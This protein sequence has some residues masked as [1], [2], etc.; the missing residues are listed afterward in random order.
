MGK[1]GLVKVTQSLDRTNFG[2]KID[3]VVH[4]A[5]SL[6]VIFEVSIFWHPA[7]PCQLASPHFPGSRLDPPGVE[8]RPET[9]FDALSKQQCKR[10][11]RCGLITL[12]TSPVPEVSS[13]SCSRGLQGAAGGFLR[14]LWLP[15][16]RFSH[17]WPLRW[18]GGGKLAACWSGQGWLEHCPTDLS[19]RK[20]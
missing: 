10:V 4:L 12:S 19:C 16:W 6:G 7:R 8:R 2:S 20:L 13:R 18:S 9:F 14:V 11:S 5:V 17:G 15:C 1:N 3:F